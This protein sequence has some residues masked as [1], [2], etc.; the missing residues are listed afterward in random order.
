M[1]YLAEASNNSGWAICCAYIGREDVILVQRVI[2][3]SEPIRLTRPN[4]NPI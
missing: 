4:L 1:T 3:E 2:T